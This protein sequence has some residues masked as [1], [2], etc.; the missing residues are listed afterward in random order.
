[1]KKA[2]TSGGAFGDLFALRLLGASEFLKGPIEGHLDGFRR[3]LGREAGHG[4]GKVAYL[5]LAVQARNRASLDGS[6]L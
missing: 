6:Q 2:P 3:L 4:G 5:G 1:M